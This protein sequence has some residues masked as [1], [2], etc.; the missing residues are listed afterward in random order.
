MPRNG[1]GLME[2]IYS[3]VTNAA[4]D[5]NIEPDLMDEDTDDIA[6]EITNSV[7]K[8]GQTTMTGN[9]KMGNNK[10][11]GMAN[12]T[13]RTDATAIAQ[14][15]DNTAT[16]M[17]STGSADAYV[18]T[19]SP[20]ITAYAA[21]QSFIFKANFSNSSATTVAISGLTAK[22]VKKN[23][24]SALEANDIQSGQLVIIAYDGTNFQLLGAGNVD[25]RTIS[26][27][28]LKDYAETLVTAN[29]STAYTIDLDNGNAFKITLTGNCTFTF[30]NPPASDNGG[31][32]LFL[33][34]DGTGSRTTTWPASVDWGQGIAPT[35]VTAA[36]TVNIFCFE[37]IDA[38]TT[39]YGFLSG[40]Q[41]A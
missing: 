3:W 30:S 12:G 2:R 22:A 28:T 4:G 31:F 7:A 29:S 8:D 18:L 5:I 16:Y 9:L 20:A 13:A 21:G 38:G 24:S 39:W 41:M 26:Q 32:K 6:A 35:L 10:V 14:L 1:S 27:V 19:P 33:I 17:T 23:I 11:T 37:T 34:Q 15:Q 36:G 25:G 40:E